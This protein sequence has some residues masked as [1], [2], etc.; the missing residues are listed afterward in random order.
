MKILTI[1]AHPD[2]ETIFS[3]GTMVLLNRAGA[4]I[5]FLC[6]TRGEGGELGEP[7][8]SSR[9]DIHIYRER[10]LIQAIEA[11]GGGS[12]S[13]L[14]YLDPLIGESDQLYPYTENFDG[15]AGKITR[16]I[17]EIQPDAIITHG[18]N[19]EYGHPGHI[20]TNMAVRAAV[21]QLEKDAPLLYTFSAI[22]PDHP[23]TRQA[24]SAD[25]AH[26]ILDVSSAMAQKARAAYCHISQHALFLRRGSKQAGYRLTI[27][28]ILLSVESFHRVHP[29][30]KGEP[31]D[32]FIQILSP[33]RRN[34]P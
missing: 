16:G 11:L 5:H 6:A 4:Q 20:L 25:P 24:N 7:A 14:G 1:F 34:K 8:V 3:G 12:L 33:W 28:E 15:L 27:P 22:F 31:Q 19:G 26:L 21:E 32:E 18:S 10:E 9:K 13:F 30:L 23:R 2:D 29:P 17:Q